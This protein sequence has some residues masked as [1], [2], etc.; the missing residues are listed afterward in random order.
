M[1]NQSSTDSTPICDEYDYS[2]PEGQRAL[3]AALGLILEIRDDQ[4]GPMARR[5]ALYERTLGAAVIPL[6]L[7][8]AFIVVARRIGERRR[9]PG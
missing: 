7:R 6:L 3:T 9:S 1:P 2:T 8:R 4:T 5:L